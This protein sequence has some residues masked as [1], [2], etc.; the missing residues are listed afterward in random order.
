MIDEAVTDIEPWIGTL[1]ACRAIGASR[2]SVSAPRTPPQ[3]ALSV[4]S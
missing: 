3:R 1:L 4:F 2:A